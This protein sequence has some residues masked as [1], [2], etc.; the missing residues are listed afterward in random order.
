MSNL[1]SGLLFGTLGPTKA[2]NLRRLFI[3][4]A[5]AR[6]PDPP[7]C[8]PRFQRCQPLVWLLQRVCHFVGAEGNA[9]DSAGQN[10]GILYN[11]VSFASGMVGRAFV[12][13]GTSS[14]VEVPDSPSLRLTNVLTIEFWV[15]RQDLQVDDYI[16]NKGGD[17]TR[18]D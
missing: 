12:F 15:K 10:N 1:L 2:V 4:A 9:N 16:L 6:W 11:G 17:Y 5:G 13:N 8:L 7:S 14:Y 3:N 18:G